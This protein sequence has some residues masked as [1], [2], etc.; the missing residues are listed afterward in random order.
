MCVFRKPNHLAISFQVK[1]MASSP[2][3]REKSIEFG[4]GLGF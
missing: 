1:E 4:I 3:S 2:Y